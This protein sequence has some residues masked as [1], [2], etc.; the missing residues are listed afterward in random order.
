M[1]ELPKWYTNAKPPM[2]PGARE[3]ETWDKLKVLGELIKQVPEFDGTPTIQKATVQEVYFEIDKLRFMDVTPW[4]L[5][6][7]KLLDVEH[8]LPKIF[9]AGRRTTY[10]SYVI[11][12]AR[13]IYKKWIAQVFDGSNMFRGIKNMI[14]EKAAKGQGPSIDQAFKID[15]H[16]FGEG[17]LVN[18][19]WFAN[20]L[21]ALRDGVHGSA[22]GGISGIEGKG[23]TS[24]SMSG[25]MYADT[26]V[27]CAMYNWFSY[28]WG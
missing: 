12:D 11:N 6:R 14:K 15:W 19:D 28:D 9:S 5:K 21:C 25:D 20:Q 23:A 8:G 16:F 4:G 27:S 1:G 24:I 3:R 2:H 22:Q 10:P 18:G 13:G 26:D 17:H 7:A